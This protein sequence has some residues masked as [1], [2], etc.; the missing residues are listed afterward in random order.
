MRMRRLTKRS[1]RSLLTIDPCLSLYPFK[2]YK[3][4]CI[5]VNMVFYLDYYLT[6]QSYGASLFL[7]VVSRGAVT[8]PEGSD[9][10]GPVGR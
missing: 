9:T 3:L 6:L 5:Y 4:Y 7:V 10:H 2:K 8:V 1:G